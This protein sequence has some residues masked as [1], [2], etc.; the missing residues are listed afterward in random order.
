[1]RPSNLA[2]INRYA[3]YQDYIYPLLEL[4]WQIQNQ[5]REKPSAK[6]QNEWIEEY[7][8]SSPERLFIS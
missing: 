2:K 6:L 4:T 1:M 5:T 7:F 3:Y 8:N